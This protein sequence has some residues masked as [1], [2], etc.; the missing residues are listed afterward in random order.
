[1]AAQVFFEVTAGDDQHVTYRYGVDKLN[2]DRHMTIDKQTE[3][4]I[5]E[6][7]TFN[8]TFT[9]SGIMRYRRHL[10]T[11]PERGVNQT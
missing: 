9:F 1:M 10:G 2:M 8:V 11:W 7:P 4:P 3:R 6:H 5:D